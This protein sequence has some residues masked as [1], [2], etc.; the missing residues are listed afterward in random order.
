MSQIAARLF[1]LLQQVLPKH[2]LTG[3]VFRLARVRATSLKNFLIRHFIKLYDVDIEEVSLPVPDGFDSFNA[4]FIRELTADARPIAKEPD[5]IASPVDGT[6]SAAGLIENEAVFQAKGL[7]YSL[8]ELLATDTNEAAAYV[9][10]AFATIYLAP[11]NY[12]RVHAPIDGELVA[13]RYVP[14]HLFSVNE[15][16]VAGLPQLFVRNER[17]ILHL[18]T[19]TGPMVLVLVG[20]MNVG[21]IS[22]KWT[23]TIR[24]RKTGVVEQM[25][26]NTDESARRF[27]KGDCLGWFNMGSTVIL[28][29][30]GGTT[31]EFAELASKQAVRMGQPIGRTMSTP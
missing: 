18:Q 23:G 13:A 5:V 27:R 17:L 4:F 24:P 9:N 12:H 14:G 29:A 15:A 19:A 6:V 21:S 30:P 2:F 26:I 8:F 11:Y 25:E 16:T 31:G 28:L 10:G 7:R 3:I 22:T 20:A 1:V